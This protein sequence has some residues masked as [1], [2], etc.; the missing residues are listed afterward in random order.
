M[1]NNNDKKTATDKVL[2]AIKAG[3]LKKLPGWHFLLKTILKIT[4][5][6]I[7]SL[8]LLHLVSFILFMIHRMGVIYAPHFGFHGWFAFFGALPLHLVLLSIIF[9]IFLLILVRRYPLVYRH[10]LLYSAIGIVLLMIIGGHMVAKTEFHA[11]LLNSAKDI[12]IF[13]ELYRRYGMHE[14]HNMHAGVII[15][16]NESGFVMKNRR[17]DT[18]TVII[19]PET[20]VLTGAVFEKG[21]EVFVFGD[22]N[23]GIVQA[24]GLHK[25][26]NR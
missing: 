13:G 15:E 23:D 7:I 10:P 18:L 5:V 26:G 17:D 22:R 25:I 12:P 8:M 2:E 16:T 4:G 21:D 3:R 1:N 14:S 11:R 24:L 9:V 19:G 20:R 6:V